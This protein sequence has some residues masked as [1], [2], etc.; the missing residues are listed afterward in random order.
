MKF[1]LP[2]L[3]AFTLSLPATRLKV[4]ATVTDMADLVQ[5]I[6]GNEVEVMTFAP[7]RGN[8]H[9]LIAK[10][11]FIKQL[12]QADMFIQNGFE[13][14]AGWVP[15]LLKSCR[16]AKVQP[17]A[18][19]HIDPSNVIKPIFDMKGKLSRA[20]GHVH[21][22]G[23][24]HYML[25]PANALLVAHL[26]NSRLKVIRPEKAEYFNNNLTGFQSQLISLLIGEKLA[27]KYSSA[28]LAK[29]IKLGRLE[30][31]LELSR[32]E[33]ELGGW[34]GKLAA[35]DNKKFVADHANYAYFIKRF[36]IA[37]VAYLEP[38]PGMEPTT[39]HLINLIQK[40]PEMGVRG[41]LTN[42]YFPP[43]FSQ[44]VARE[45]K[46]PILRMAHQTGALEGCETY[47]KMIDYNV[48]QILKTLSD[49]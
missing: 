40:I 39:S 33:N 41:V 47:L 29:L 19:G 37:V 20:S 48:N 12:S 4:C 16:N 30:Q 2:I 38:K 42:T 36:N 10:P 25:D 27:S 17:H 32:Q 45:T 8:P 43:K 9:F 23:N 22:N 6:G 21:P 34:L 5:V 26:I 35:H 11:N 18:I 24:P 3:L 31:F 1:I 7:A 13:L 44:M 49:E 46:L 28:K 14:E 15:V